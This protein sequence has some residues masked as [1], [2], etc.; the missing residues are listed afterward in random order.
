MA[1]MT[2]IAANGG[3]LPLRPSNGR[4]SGTNLTCGARGGVCGVGVSFGMGVPPRFDPVVDELV[5]E[6]QQQVQSALEPRAPPA[7]PTETRWN[8]R[9]ATLGYCRFKRRGGFKRR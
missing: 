4:V 2:A 9:H 6:S 3:F 8:R 7:R 5:G 1:T